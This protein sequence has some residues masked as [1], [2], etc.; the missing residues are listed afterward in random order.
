MHLKIVGDL[1]QSNPT[2]SEC[3]PPLVVAMKLS[4]LKCAAHKMHP[5]KQTKKKVTRRDTTMEYSNIGHVTVV[6]S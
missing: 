2:N 1:A 3:L 5:N 6:V 4:V